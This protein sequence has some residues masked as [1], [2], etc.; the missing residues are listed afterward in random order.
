[1]HRRGVL[2]PIA[3]YTQLYKPMLKKGW[4]QACST[5][6]PTLL[7]ERIATQISGEPISSSSWIKNSRTLWRSLGS[8]TDLW[9]HQEHGRGGSAWPACAV[10]TAHL[11]TKPAVF[12]IGDHMMAEEIQRGILKLEEQSQQIQHQKHDFRRKLSDLE[13]QAQE[14]QQGTATL[15]Q[16]VEELDG[17]ISRLGTAIVNEK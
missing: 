3:V 2:I 1:M 11:E 14:V 15:R 4:W 10:T 9:G 7:R 12:H 6:R 13:Q 17:D 5:G 8:R 16:E